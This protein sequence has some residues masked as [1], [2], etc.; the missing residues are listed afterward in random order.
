MDQYEYIRTARRVYKKGIREI[1]RETGHSRPTIR[2]VLAGEYAGY[3]ERE[4]QSYPVLEAHRGSIER[5][6]KE[7]Q[8][9]PKKQRHT[10]RRIYRRLVEEEGYE[11]SESN[12]RYYVRMAKAK[13]ETGSSSAFLILKPD[14]G[15]EADADWGRAMALLRGAK[16]PFHYFCLRPRFSGKHFVCA[17]PCEKQ[18]AFFDAHVKAFNFFGGV[19]SRI[20]YDNLTSAVRKVLQGRNRIEQDSF[21]R[22]RSFYNFEARFC[23]PGSANEKGGA[24]GA[25]G[26][27]RRNYMVP[28]PVADSFEELN[29]RLLKSCLLY[30]G[31]VI[32]GRTE[33]VDA[34][35]EKER[36]H[37]IALPSVPYS[38]V[39]VLDAKV[40]KYSTVMADKN[41]YSVP[42]PHV[43]LKVKIQL[44][45]DRI[46][47]FYGGKKIA[48]HERLFGNNKWQLNPQHYLELIRRKPGAFESAL[49][50]RQWRPSWPPCVE[51]LLERF[52]EKQGETAGIKDFIAVLMLYRDYDKNEIEAA[53]EL[54]LESGLSNSEGIRH[55]LIYSG[56]E[57]QF[58]PLAGWP[59][60]TVPDVTLYGKLGAIR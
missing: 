7:D 5:W 60:T 59:S 36:E 48:S 50:I 18:E 17:Y 52:K 13:L 46:E 30:G 42:T 53:V 4:S 45:I 21:I 43:R 33:T 34:L 10:A 20:I 28:M 6:L 9:R 31:H 25:I 27:V 32:E 58:A 11:G 35:F 2:K 38:N 1:E 15:R 56:P 14:C 44:S 3:K 57:E 54:A 39:R 47:I 19:F 51:K 40:D 26:Y 22:F 41:H 12:V 49:V 8:E 37:L 24:E 55:I 29:E 16:T 23:N